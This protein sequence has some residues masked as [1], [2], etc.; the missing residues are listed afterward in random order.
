MR[1][2]NFS[3]ALAADAAAMCFK[4]LMEKEGLTFPES[5]EQVANFV[6][7]PMPAG[8]GKA[9]AP[10]SPLKKVYQGGLSVLSAPLASD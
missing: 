1:P 2:T 9:V 5:V 10:I 6:N 7:I 8:L 3:N 4:F